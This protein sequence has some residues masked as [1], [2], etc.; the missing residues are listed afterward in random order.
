MAARKKRDDHRRLLEALR[1][2]LRRDLLRLVT[3]RGA[4]SPIRA[5]RE[6][7]R[8]VSVVG[9]HLRELAKEGVVVVLDDESATS[10]LER[11]YVP[12]DA[13]RNAPA[14]RE[15]IGLSERES[16]REAYDRYA[17]V[18]DEC[19]AEN[20]YEMWLGE[21]LL[22]ELEK[23]GLQK[24]WALDVGCGTG[25]A[26]EPLLDRGWQVVGCDVSPGMLAEAA[27]K[28]GSAVQLLELDA[29]DLPS[30]SP[31]PG[32]PEEAAFDLVLLL[33]DVINYLTEAG[34]LELVFSGIK[35]N[36]NRDHGLLVFDAN[37]VALFRDDFVAG[38]TE[39]V[40]ERGWEWRGLSEKAEPEGLYEARFSGQDVESHVHRQRHWPVEQIRAA[41]EAAGLRC[42][43][44]LGQREEGGRV[45]LS[46]SPDEERDS[47]VV[48]VAAPAGATTA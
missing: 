39:E 46:D 23:H 34:D 22:P 29:H 25:R 36:L 28:F 14:V 18:Y 37:T 4:L 20:D 8:P 11:L 47:K 21:V 1:H 31:G 7:E 41:L 17:P 35:R 5:A 43:A 6:V 19:N 45:L 3:E 16:A 2:P 15:A 24:G 27:R 42:L 12:A 38:V 13:V 33:N 30:I 44:A 26:F 10:T 48:Y 32:L 9:Y 40:D